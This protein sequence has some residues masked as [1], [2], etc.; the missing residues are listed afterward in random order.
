MTG[1]SAQRTVIAAVLVN[2]GLITARDLTTDGKLPSG[3]VALG[4]GLSAVLL[5]FLAQGSPELG[6][7]FA[8]LFLTAGVLTLGGQTF[9]NLSK[10]LT[11]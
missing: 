6:G 9:G 8:L 1:A 11:K 10:G 4:L 2:G 7:A 3:R 5:S